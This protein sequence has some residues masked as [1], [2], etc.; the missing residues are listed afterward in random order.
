VN[1]DADRQRVLDALRGVHATRQ[2]LERRERGYVMLA[3]RLGLSWQTIADALGTTHATMRTRYG[4]RKKKST[5][6]RDG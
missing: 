6:R 3:R 4:D 1:R 5:G 2:A